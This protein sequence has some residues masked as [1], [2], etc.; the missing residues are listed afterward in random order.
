M[1]NSIRVNRHDAAFSVW[2]RINDYIIV[3]EKKRV[4]GLSN[5]MLPYNFNRVGLPGLWYWANY[6]DIAQFYTPYYWDLKQVYGFW[7][8]S[9]YSRSFFGIFIS[10]VLVLLMKR[11]VGRFLH[12]IRCVGYIVGGR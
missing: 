2:R 11:G 12:H 5:M 6:P 1:R 7:G 4:P 8:S 9:Q 3:K 10:R